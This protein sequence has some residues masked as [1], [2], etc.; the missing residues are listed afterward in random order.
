MRQ[1]ELEEEPIAIPS[2]EESLSIKSTQSLSPTPPDSMAMTVAV[3]ISLGVCSTW[4]ETVSEVNAL[5]AA[6]RASEPD[7][8]GSRTASTPCC[9]A[10][11]A[12]GRSISL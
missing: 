6:Q 12:P 4:P 2:P 3:E 9:S 8:G 1:R 10:N 7:S 5:A 11:A